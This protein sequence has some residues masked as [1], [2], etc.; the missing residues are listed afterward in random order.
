MHVGVST[1]W[2]SRARGAAGAHAGRGPA[3]PWRAGLRAGGLPSSAG[4]GGHPG[5]AAR[6]A[7]GV[8]KQGALQRGLRRVGHRPLGLAGGLAPAL[9]PA[10]GDAGERGPA[11]RPRGHARADRYRTLGGGGGPGSGARRGGGAG[12]ECAWGQG[13]GFGVWS[14]PAPARVSS[15]RGGLGVGLQSASGRCAQPTSMKCP[16]PTVTGRVPLASPS[17]CGRRPHT[18]SGTGVVSRRREHATPQ[19]CRSQA[20]AACGAVCAMPESEPCG[21]TRTHV[22][23]PRAA[24]WGLHVTL[25]TGPAAETGGS[26]GDRST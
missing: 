4:E 7:A 25:L 17:W 8:D 20:H 22:A 2:V 6:R 10:H 11:R 9:Q 21:I 16:C 19:Q 14:G 12:A 23:A 18:G 24:L 26:R 3:N 1:D 13:C 5:A 15:C